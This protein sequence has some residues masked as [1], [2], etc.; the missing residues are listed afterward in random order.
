MIVETQEHVLHTVSQWYQVGN[1]TPLVLLAPR[2]FISPLAYPTQKVAEIY[3]KVTEPCNFVTELENSSWNVLCLLRS[4][5]AYIET[6]H[7]LP[8]KRSYLF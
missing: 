3:N 7:S 4:K 6:E 5:V 8:Q 2:L 1:V